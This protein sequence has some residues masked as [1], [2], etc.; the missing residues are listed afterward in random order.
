MTDELLK[1]PAIVQ[2][3]DRNLAETIWDIR[4]TYHPDQITCPDDLGS[5]RRCYTKLYPVLYWG[6]PGC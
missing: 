6:L 1:C 3:L 4:A 5:Y 2:V